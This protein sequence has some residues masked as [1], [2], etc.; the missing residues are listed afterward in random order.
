MRKFGNFEIIGAAIATIGIMFLIMDGLSCLN[1]FQMEGSG[2]SLG[3]ISL[4]MATNGYLILLYG[5][6][7]NRAGVAAPVA[8]QA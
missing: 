6:S 3:I 5:I 7:S 4:L 1:V 2:L 8:A